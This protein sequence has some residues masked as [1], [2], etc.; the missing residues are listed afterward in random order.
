MCDASASAVAGDASALADACGLVSP[1]Q[2]GW[3]LGYPCVFLFAAE[4]RCA[5]HAWLRRARTRCSCGLCTGG[6]AAASA[7]LAGAALRVFQLHGK[8]AALLQEPAVLLSFSVPE[9]LLA[10]AARCVL[11]ARR[12]LRPWV[13]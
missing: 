9:P 10:E 5:E 7:S 12:R 6:S 8:C 13:C 1:T 11:C 4:R 2:H 3:L